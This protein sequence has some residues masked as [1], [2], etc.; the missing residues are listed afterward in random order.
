MPQ[1]VFENKRMKRKKIKGLRDDIGLKLLLKVKIK[2]DS[3]DS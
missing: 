3:K 2:K 1:E